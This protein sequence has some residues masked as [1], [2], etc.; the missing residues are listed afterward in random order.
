M[1]YIFG[2]AIA[3]FLL[4]SCQKNIQ[5]TETTVEVAEPVVN[6]RM[7]AMPKENLIALYNAADDIDIQFLEKSFSM[8]APEA[9]AK[10][11]IAHISDQG[12]DK[13]AC[14]EI[15]YL[16]VKSKGEQIAHI[17]AF[18]ANGCAYYV[19]YENSR[20]KYVNAMTQGGADSFNR[21]LTQVNTSPQ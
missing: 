21:I 2:F 19:F 7:P 6:L 3:L 18:L 13:T 16:F 14:T 12:A 11:T 4:A 17:G 20:P 8:N 15:C 10:N 9:M 5:E 1:K